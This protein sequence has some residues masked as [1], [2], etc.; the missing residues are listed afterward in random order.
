[1]YKPGAV[2]KS[3]DELV[4]QEFV[5]AHGKR[6]HHGWVLG[7]QLNMAMLWIQRG[8]LRRAEKVEE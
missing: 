6:Y 8:W 3:L 5:F 1:M 7:W 2:I 4:Q